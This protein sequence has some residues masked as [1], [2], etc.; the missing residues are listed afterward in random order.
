M[1]KLTVRF[2][3]NISHSSDEILNYESYHTPI[4]G[5]IYTVLN[6]ESYHAPTNGAIYTV[7]NCESYHTGTN[8][9][10]Y[11]VFQLAL[12]LRVTRAMYL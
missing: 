1:T 5:A 8:G 9:A 12:I 6:Y 2:S 3:N 11:T 10:I 7:L 4:N